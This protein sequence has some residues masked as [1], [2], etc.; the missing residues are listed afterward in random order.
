M[1]CSDADHSATDLAIK[2][3]AGQ[4]SE[5][6]VTVDTRIHEPVSND[7]LIEETFNDVTLHNWLM[8][9]QQICLTMQAI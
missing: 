6:D 1:K 8:L 3:T 9:T 4:D 2:E 7:S 5:K